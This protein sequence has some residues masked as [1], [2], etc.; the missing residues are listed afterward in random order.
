MRPRTVYGITGEG[1]TALQHWLDEPSAPRAWEFEA[2]LKVFFADAGTLDQLRGT[3]AAVEQEAVEQEAV[4]RL[5][6]LAAMAEQAWPGPQSS[7]SGSTS[8]PSR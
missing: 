8:T 5:G 4:E 7:R 1:R 2:L 3:L 6:E